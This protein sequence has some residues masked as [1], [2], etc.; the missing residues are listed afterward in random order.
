MCCQKHSVTILIYYKQK[1]HHLFRAWLILQ[2]IQQP[3]LKWSC[4]SSRRLLISNI[5]LRRLSEL[6]A[7][8]MPNMVIL[9]CVQVELLHNTWILTTPMLMLVFLNMVKI[10][11]I[12]GVPVWMFMLVITVN[13]TSSTS[14]FKLVVPALLLVMF[15]NMN[16]GVIN[17]NTATPKISDSLIVRLKM[18]IPPVIERIKQSFLM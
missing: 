9:P 10:I 16:M 3:V 14:S 5:H 2:M 1:N 11:I 17:I 13:T 18:V 6:S 8:M 4:L 12:I 15:S 7:S